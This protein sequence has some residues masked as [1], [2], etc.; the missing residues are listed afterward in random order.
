MPKKAECVKFKNFERKIKSVI[1]IFADFESILA[2]KDNGK[3]NP[4]KSYTNNYQKQNIKNIS[5]TYCLLFW[6][7]TSM[8]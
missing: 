6:L 3:Q 8:C 7:Q 2:P 1:M 5:K 4:E